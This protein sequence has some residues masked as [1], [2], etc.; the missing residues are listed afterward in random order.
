MV[1]DRLLYQD[2]LHRSTSPYFV[3]Y[4]CNKEFYRLPY[5]FVKARGIVAVMV[6]TASLEFSSTRIVSK[7][8][9][10]YVPV[11]LSCYARERHP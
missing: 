7:Y 4:D 11:P 10:R 3:Q 1:L 8:W 9:L 5:D 6:A 2:Y